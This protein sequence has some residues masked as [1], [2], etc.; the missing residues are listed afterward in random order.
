MQEVNFIEF[1]MLQDM[2]MMLHFFIR[3]QFP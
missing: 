3:L 1:S 2:L